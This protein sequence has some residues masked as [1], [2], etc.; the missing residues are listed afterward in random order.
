M[1]RFGAR[2]LP[3]KHSTSKLLSPNRGFAAG[4]DGHAYFSYDTGNPNGAGIDVFS[5]QNGL[6]CPSTKISLGTLRFPALDTDA[7]GNLYVG[8]YQPTRS[9]V[10]YLEVF[11]PGG[12]ALIGIYPYAYNSYNSLP[13]TVW[14]R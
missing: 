3:R 2:L 5:S 10:P 4:S 1:V 7:A 11:K 6:V 13:G 8:L 12:R 9:S 14:V